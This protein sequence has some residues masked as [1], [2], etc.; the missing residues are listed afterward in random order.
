MKKITTIPRSKCESGKLI[1]ALDITKERAIELNE[2]ALSIKIKHED[3]GDL[4]DVL[5]ELSDHLED[6]P[7]EL[8]HTLI[9]IG[10]VAVYDTIMKTGAIGVIVLNMIGINPKKL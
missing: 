4:A 10:R 5:E 7:N 2:L 6:N 8:A 1:E 9:E 3:T